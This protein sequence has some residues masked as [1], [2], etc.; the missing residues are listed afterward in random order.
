MNEQDQVPKLLA[1]YMRRNDRNWAYLIWTCKRLF[2]KQMQQTMQNAGAEPFKT[3]YI[4][5]LAAVS[6]KKITNREL[7]KRA[8]V[9]KQAMSRTVKEMEELGLI[10]TE[11]NQ[12]DGRSAY[13]SLTPEGQKRLLLVKQA[14]QSIMDQYQQVVGEDNFT[15]AVDVLRQIVTYHESLDQNDSGDE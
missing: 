13:I 4:P 15:I 7:A 10:R 1:D 9:P 2:E 6:L 3:S 14:Q 11:K 8:K 5:F 12:K